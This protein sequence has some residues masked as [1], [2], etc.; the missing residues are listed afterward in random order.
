VGIK[1]KYGG[2]NIKKIESTIKN[3]TLDQKHQLFQNIVLIIDDIKLDNSIYNIVIEPIKMESFYS[4]YIYANGTNYSI[5]LDSTIDEETKKIGFAKEIA[6]YY[7]KMRRDAGLH[8]WDKIQLGYN[9][10][11]NYNLDDDK[12]NDE[13]YKT[14][15]YK[16]QKLSS[17]SIDSNSIILERNLDEY[18][19]ELKNTDN[20]YNMKL[21]LL[22]SN[23]NHQE[24]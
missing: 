3:L 5:Y 19:G 18:L 22:K 17:N 4:E 10:N 16:T 9:G 15:G 7:Q 1:E 6:S 8:P 2:N 23:Q 20:K 21:Y 12:L 11:P 14:C 13:I 24:I